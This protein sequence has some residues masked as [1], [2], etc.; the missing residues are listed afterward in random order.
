MQL[1]QTIRLLTRLETTLERRRTTKD[2]LESIQTTDNDAQSA[3]YVSSFESNALQNKKY[4]YI[5]SYSLKVMIWLV[6]IF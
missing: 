3:N 1:P 2:R 5:G 6:Q 4:D